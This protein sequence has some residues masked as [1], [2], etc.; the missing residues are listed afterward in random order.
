M[1][2]PMFLSILKN[3]FFHSLYLTNYSVVDS[4]AV[5]HKNEAVIASQKLHRD[6]HYSII[7]PR[8]FSSAKPT[9]LVFLLDGQDYEA[10]HLEQTLAAFYQENQVVNWVFVPVSTNENRL[11][12]YGVIDK[13]DYKNRGALATAY[14]QFWE[15]EL[16]PTV[17]QKIGVT[18][19]AEI[20][21]CGFSLSG[22]AAFDLAW[23]LP[24]ISKVGVF[25]GSF[26]WR[27]KAYEDDYDDYNGRIMHVKV[28]ETKSPKE[29][30]AVWLQCG[31][32][33]EKDDRNNNGIIDSIEDTLDLI[34]ELENKN[35]RNVHYREV[36]G[37]Q[38]NPATWGQVMP[39]FL[40]WLK[41]TN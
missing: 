9:K 2:I 40:H 35:V 22:L 11:Q 36:I 29:T 41:V 24:M 26:W 4:S 14:A 20:S 15:L 18:E 5:F 12:E 23:S 1:I 7:Q 37:G 6:V 21:I 25:S 13:P 38:H 16:L 39:E 34:Q 3:I 31:T 33:D 30:L 27:S 17:C 28:R 8:D 32:E 19:I 10:L